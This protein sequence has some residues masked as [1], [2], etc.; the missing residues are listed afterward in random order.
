MRAHTLWL[1]L[2]FYASSSL[3]Q[4]SDSIYFSL[5]RQEDN[6]S[7]LVNHSDKSTYEKLKYLPLG[8]SASL[9][10]GGS[11]RL[12]AESFINEDFVSGG[13]QDNFWLLNR[14]MWHTHFKWGSRFELFAE[15]SNANIA[16]KVNKSPVDKDALSVN[17][18]FANYHFNDS[19]R[20]GV[21]RY[22]LKIGSRRLFDPREGPNVRRSF[23]L[24]KLRFRRERFSASAIYGTLVRPN[25]SVFDNDFLAFDE[26]I[27]G[28]Y[29][30]T[31][32]FDKCYLD[33]YAMYQKDGDVTYNAGTENEQRVSLG[34][35]HHGEY[36]ALQFDSEAIY[37]LG[38]FGDQKIAAWTISSKLERQFTLF[39]RVFSTGVKTELIS[40]DRDSSD[41]W[42]NTFDGLYPRGAYFGRV[43]RFGPA[44]LIDLHPYVN[45]VFGKFFAE[46]DYD[47][48]WR[49][50]TADGLYNPALILQYKDVNDRRFIAHQL[51][52][53][54]SYQFGQNITL[55]M[56]TNFIFPGDFLNYSGLSDHL[57]HFVFTTEFKF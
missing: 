11:V 9:S 32:L 19:W 6:L 34:V 44:N 35:R 33:L 16:D 36:R 50:S 17:Q 14:N 42:Q 1:T 28:I 3:S 45:L 24:I 21:G 54:I 8:S 56:E 26:V 2:L 22:N 40:G 38:Q 53:L 41:N 57:F 4:L 51:G 52:T 39:R 5:L 13:N 20:I 37:Q 23:D 7:S 18:L 10:F 43:A 47:F 25:P 31:Q 49:F 27:S 29:T 12:Q 30:S 55:E 48:F 15:L 46:V